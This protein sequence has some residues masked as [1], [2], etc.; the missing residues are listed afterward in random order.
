MKKLKALVWLFFFAGNVGC[1]LGQIV[2]FAL[3]KDTAI[4]AMIVHVVIARFMWDYK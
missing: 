1:A 2:L 4:I 3:G